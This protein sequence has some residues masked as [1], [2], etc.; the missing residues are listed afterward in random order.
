MLRSRARPT[1]RRITGIDAL[2]DRS[3]VRGIVLPEPSAVLVEACAAGAS[4]YLDPAPCGRPDRSCRSLAG[5]YMPRPS[6]RTATA[7]RPTA[8]VSRASFLRSRS[9]ARSRA[10]T[11]IYKRT[12]DP[13]HR[14]GGDV[15]TE[16]LCARAR[17]FGE[18]P[19]EGVGIGGDDLLFTREQRVDCLRSTARFRISAVAVA[20]SAAAR[21]PRGANTNR[22]NAVS[23][24]S[25]GARCLI[26]SSS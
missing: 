24:G 17:L 20:S 26:A 13:D 6:A 16:V 23:A 10:R 19:C 8:T 25:P 9:P 4:T 14:V 21:N 2:T 12:V 15:R 5:A 3:R 7:A 11:K 22:A 1:T 18:Q